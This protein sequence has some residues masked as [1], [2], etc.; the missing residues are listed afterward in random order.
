MT[1]GKGKEQAYDISFSSL[2]GINYDWREKRQ[3]QQS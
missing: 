2:A 1:L 3:R